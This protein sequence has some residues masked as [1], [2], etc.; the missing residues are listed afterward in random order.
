VG[1]VK[2]RYI[3]TVEHMKVFSTYVICIEAQIKPIHVEGSLL[4]VYHEYSAQGRVRSNTRP[5]LA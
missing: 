3:L 2:R 1:N 5:G 4:I